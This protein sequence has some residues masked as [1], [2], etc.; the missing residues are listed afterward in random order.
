MDILCTEAL[1]TSFAERLRAAA[2]EAG[3][4]AMGAD[5]AIRAVGGPGTPEGEAARPEVVISS[6]DLWVEGGAYRPF[7]TYL[8]SLPPSLRWL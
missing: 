8:A 5:G 7:F 1:W 3:W 6:Y 2:P 4:L